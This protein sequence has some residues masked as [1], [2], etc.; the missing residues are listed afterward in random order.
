MCF[1]SNSRELRGK[2]GDYVFVGD[3][4]LDRVVTGNET[5]VK[6]VTCDTKRKIYGLGTHKFS[7]KTKE[8]LVNFVSKEDHGDFFWD[9]KVCF[10]CISPNVVQ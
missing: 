8:M 5:W 2:F 6:H 9:G 1:N 10:G 7:Q 3:S 4:L